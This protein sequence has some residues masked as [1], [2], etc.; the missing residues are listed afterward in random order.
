MVRPSAVCEIAFATDPGA[1]PTWVDVSQWL[2]E[3]TVER[4]RQQELNRV[5]AGTARIVLDNQDRRFDPSNAA[6]PYAPNVVPMRRVRLSALYNSVTY[7]LFSGYVETWPPEYPGPLDS[8]V[9][10]QATD[11]F[12]VFNLANL[13]S[14]L[15]SSLVKG[16]SPVAYWRLGETTGTSAADS[17]GNSHIG[18]YTGSFAL[19]QPGALPADPDAA[20][21]LNGSSSYVTVPST[22]AFDLSTAFSLE[23]WVKP[24]NVAGGSQGIFNRLG[25]WFMSMGAIVN[26]QLRLTDR[27]GHTIDWNGVTLADGNWYHVVVVKPD[28]TLTNARLYVNGVA[29]APSATSGPWSPTAGANS[30]QLG[31]IET[32]TLFFNGVIDEAAV[33]SAGLSATQIAEHYAAGAGVFY[34]QSS[35]ARISAVLDVIGWPSADRSIAA[36]DSTIQQVAL[37]NVSALQHFGDVAD[38]ENGL[39]F[40]T[41]DGKLKFVNRG[42]LI[43]SSVYTTSQG[44]FGDG[45]G[46]ELLYVDV[47]FD[48]SDVQL[49]NDVRITREGGT[50]QVATDANSQARY[51]PRTLSKTGMLMASD[52]DALAAAQW[53][54]DHYRTPALRVESLEL[55]GEVDPANLW[56]Q[57]FGRELGERVTV[58]KSPPG[59][60]A[61]I[62]Q[63]GYLQRIEHRFVAEGGVWGTTWQLSPA[64]LQLYWILQDPAQ[65][66]LDSTTVLSY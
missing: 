61:R 38:A 48:Y 32:P 62:E 56:P 13:P 46:S 41:G 24:A 47:K 15:Y 23:A 44:T 50:M 20:V 66:I 33:Y 5:E 9:E 54:R 10:V 29:Y 2:M 60:G 22:G 59:G 55:D 36:G 30:V 37:N 40:M 14:Q 27:N 58:R 45:G 21:S 25:W 52:N 16:A 43:T 63:Q 8:N 65:S 18:T 19:G 57:I 34:Q 11:A 7:R 39:L 42:A 31:A 4:G 49:W 26:G 28:N 35:D 17:S 51:Y 3:F 53:L 1:T 64:D 12:K 6:S